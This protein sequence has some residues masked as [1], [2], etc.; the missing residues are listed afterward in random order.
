MNNYILLI[1]GMMAVTY[2]PRLIPLLALAERPLHPLLK[3]FLLYIPYTALS[4]LIVRGIL[5]AEPGMM[6]ATIIGITAAGLCSWFNGG[7]VF[8]VL[9]SIVASFV[10]LWLQ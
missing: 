9:A 8:S 6:L 4:A 3:R 1:L 10:F 5:Q 7:L 2:I